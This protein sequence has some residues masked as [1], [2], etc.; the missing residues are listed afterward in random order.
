MAEL[1][2]GVIGIVAAFKGAVETGI[3]I[4]S[5]FDAE[6][7]ESSGLGLYFLIEKMRLQLWGE[8]CRVRDSGSCTLRDKP[9]DLKRLVIQTLGN[10][11]KLSRAADD[12]VKEYDIATSSVQGPTNELN[13]NL[14][15]D[16]DIVHDIAKLPKAIRPRKR[17]SWVIYAKDNFKEK[18]DAIGRH[19]TYLHQITLE[20]RVAELLENGL[21]GRVLPNVNNNTNLRTLGE[22]NPEAHQSLAL[23]ALAKLH[24]QMASI[25]PKGSA[26]CVTKSDLQLF[27]R[28]SDIG[29]LKQ[30]DGATLTVRVEWNNLGTGP[31][32]DAEKYVDRINSLGYILE[33]VS[34]PA[35]R[36]PPCYGVF[37]D[38]RN[39]G[40]GTRRL[41]YVFGLPPNDSTRSSGH[42]IK[43]ETDLCTYPPIR[44]SELIRDSKRP[45]PL[46]GDRFQ[47]AYVLA[48]AFSCF[49]A[50]GWLHKGF[51]TGSIWFFQKRG[52]RVDVTQ[53]FI[54]GFQY[55]RPQGESSIAYTPLAD[56]SIEYYYHPDADRGFTKKRDL[57]SLGVVLFEIGRWIILTDL[58]TTKTKTKEKEKEKKPQ[59]RSEWRD[60]MLKGPL[61]DLGWRVGDKYQSAV[62]ALLECELPDD[63]IPHD[64]F[65]EQFLEKVMKPLSSC[66]A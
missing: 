2:L 48:C 37:D 64:Y 21:P 59:D 25:D 61:V 35:L 8:H 55:S 42:N 1:A 27:G 60:F 4:R 63:E 36:L 65:A 66:S 9:E 44:L 18:I 58:K 51:H 62:R 12:L 14:H 31:V 20:Y 32:A 6:A 7:T 23:S 19:I 22:L 57:Y 17:L 54:T 41:G 53:P 15:P 26:T 29:R 45:I 52:G 10:I 43:Y 56:R 39:T 46:L 38:S 49:H 16:S 5:F 33:K 3:F 40:H 30:P 50:A 28:S 24:H 11:E 47:L 13:D 34:E